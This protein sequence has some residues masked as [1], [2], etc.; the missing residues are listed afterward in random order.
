MLMRM[1]KGFISA[2]IIVTIFGGGL[3]F[4]S[5]N[6]NNLCGVANAQ[7]GCCSW[8][9]GVDGCDYDVG[10]QVCNDGTYSP[11]C[12]CQIIKKPYC[13]ISATPQTIIWGQNLTLKWN[14]LAGTTV[15]T[16]FMNNSNNGSLTVNPKSN[17]TYTMTVSNLRGSTS[18]QAGVVVNPKI[19]VKD[20]PMTESYIL[21]N[22][23]IDDNSQPKG[24][25]S[26][27]DEGILGS[28]EVIFKVTYT[29]DLETNRERTPIEKIIV[30]PRK[31]VTKVGTMDPTQY[32]LGVAKKSI[33]DH[34][35]IYLT[36]TLVALSF[37]GYRYRKSLLRLIKFKG[38]K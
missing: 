10:R 11:S 21:P 26:I 35:I 15:S 20:V 13:N 3:F 19:E 5:Q 8:H 27:L 30:E 36:L 16:N 25:E 1:N 31:K 29:N 23:I 6:R 18:C 22:E 33:I 12:G 37:V 17:M 14:S 7:S 32:Y 9:G 38:K 2:L 34:Y 4:Y 24:R 28:K